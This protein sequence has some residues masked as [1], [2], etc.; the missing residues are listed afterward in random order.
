MIGFFHQHDPQDRQGGVERYLATLLAA[1]GA[2]AMAVTP[3]PT[4]TASGVAEPTRSNAR[5]DVALRGSPRLPVW[6]RFV[7]G[8]FRDAPR[9]ARVLRQQGVVVCEYSR[10][11]YALFAWLFRGPRVFTIHGTGPHQSAR[12]AYVAHHACSLAMAMLATRVQIVGRDPSGVSRLCRALLKDRLAFI[13]AWHDDRFAPTP[14]PPLDGAPMRIFYAGRISEQKNPALLFAVMRE[15]AARGKDAA[16][17]HYFGSDYA[18]FVEAGLAADVENH[19]LLGPAAL[20]RAI[21]SCHVGLLCSSFGEGSP[22]IVAETLACGR[23]V[24]LPPLRTL[25]ATYGGLVGVKIARA[26]DAKTFADLL[27]ELRDEMKS[28]A[29][30]A[31]SI[32]AQVAHRSQTLATQTLLRDLESLACAPADALAAQEGTV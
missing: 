9:I 32:A 1:A 27:F 10:P 19:G 21:G 29:V 13:D 12:L 14:T 6:L 4:L 5:L 3:A 8:V 18:A 26:Y 2:R 15:L 16:S 24:V 20:A 25:E 17:L 7:L 28:A 23:G 31:A 22:F 30:D 11:E